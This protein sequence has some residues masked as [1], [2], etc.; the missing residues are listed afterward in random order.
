MNDEWYED[1]IN[2]NEGDDLSVKE[3]D[4]TSTPNDFNIST[5]FS[6]IDN[7]VIQIP[8]FQ[9]NYVW[10][11]KRASK[12]IESLILGL[13][14]P[15]IFLYEKSKNSFY[16]IDGQQR[17]L[18]I[19]FFMKQRFPT[20]KG[21][22]ALREVMSGT[23]KIEDS[24]LADDEM[25]RNFSLKLPAVTT[26]SD[27]K[28]NKLKFETLGEYKYTFEILRTIRTVV[29]KQNEPDDDSSIYEIFNRLNTG[30]QNLSPQEIRMSLYYSGFY[31]ML[32]EINHDNRWRAILRQSVPDNRLKDIEILARVFSILLA[33]EYKAPMGKFLNTES[34]R[35]IKLKDDKLEYCKKL[36]FSF[37]DSCE[38]LPSECFCSNKGK[39]VISLFEAVFIATC[40]DAFDKELLIS[41]KITIES[42]K[43]LKEDTNFKAISQDGVSSTKNVNE[44]IAKAKKTIRFE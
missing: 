37:L 9:R 38:L 36:F 44:R 42:L 10:D 3:Y 11:E 19:Y 33:K 39:F 16:V 23:Q 24:L 17:L 21:K 43:K 1:D 13:P 22:V 30:G 8:P 28:L 31:E 29:I 15:Q 25:F 41:K 34:K 7:G 32:M 12:L 4:I 2:D 14:V 20:K 26:D 35:N 6:L 27:N 5:I 40:Q 18:S